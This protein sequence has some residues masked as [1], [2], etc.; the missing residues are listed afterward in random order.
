[1]YFLKKEEE[2]E[3]EQKEREALA[4]PFVSIF[5]TDYPYDLQD[6]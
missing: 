1:V 5:K 3:R 6:P 4:F 2:R